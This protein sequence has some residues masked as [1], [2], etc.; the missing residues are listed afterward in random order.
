MCVDKNLDLM[1]FLE[2]NLMLYDFVYWKGHG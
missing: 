1:E 2:I